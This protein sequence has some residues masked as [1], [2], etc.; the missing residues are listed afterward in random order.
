[1]IRQCLSLLLVPLLLLPPG[2]CVCGASTRPCG[3]VTVEEDRDEGDLPCCEDHDGC[4]EAVTPCHPS[5][6]EGAA[7]SRSCPADQ[8]NEHAPHCPA[9]KAVVVQRPADLSRPL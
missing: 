4:H 5:H 1:M 8:H 3:E 2:V 7:F 9:L 6:Q